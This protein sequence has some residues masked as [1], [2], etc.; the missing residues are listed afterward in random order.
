VC[1]VIVKLIYVSIFISFGTCFEDSYII[2]T[3]L[4]N[5]LR[6]MEGLGNKAL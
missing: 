2:P 3:F 6:L 4:F 1:V 5:R